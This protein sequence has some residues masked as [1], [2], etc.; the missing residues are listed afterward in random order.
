MQLVEFSLYIVLCLYIT[1][2]KKKA[3]E[4]IYWKVFITNGK[5]LYTIIHA[6][7]SINTRMQ[8]SVTYLCYTIMQ[9]IQRQS[10]I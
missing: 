5:A 3:E 10:Y 6:F 9:N 8:A 2:R 7:P 4:S 1:K